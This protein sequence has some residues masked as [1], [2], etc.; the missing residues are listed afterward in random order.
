MHTSELLQS[1]DFAYWQ[2]AGDGEIA[3]DF[4]AFCLDYHNLDRVGV[5]SPCLEDGILHTGIALLAL[6]TAYYDIQR[7]RA[8]EFATYPHHFAFVGADEAGLRS[9]NGSVAGDLAGVWDAWSWM[10][11]W[12]SH[13]WLTTDPTAASMLKMVFDN[14]I[15]RLFWPA[16]WRPEPDAFQLPAYVQSMLASDLKGVYLYSVAPSPKQDSTELLGIAGTTAVTQIIDESLSNLP[17]AAKPLAHEQQPAK[18]WYRRID[19]GDFLVELADCF[20]KES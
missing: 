20:E 17:A 7:Q 4:E 9:R 14:Q 13:K 19:V 15:N 10:D 3:A 6:T 8:D 2:V 18:Q 16:G 11:V 5:V 12:P 1:T